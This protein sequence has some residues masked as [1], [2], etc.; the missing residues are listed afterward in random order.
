[1]SHGTEPDP[2]L[3]YG[4]GLALEL[5]DMGLETLL[6]TPSSS[7]AEP[8]HQAERKRM[9][10][11]VTQR[12]FIDDYSGIR[13]SKTGI[14]FKIEGAII[15]NVVRGRQEHRGEAATFSKWHYV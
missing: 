12:G 9:L 1:M 5:W 3:N 10:A 2:I 4:N 7:T 8:I 6:E 11:Q 15:W 14:R 13:V